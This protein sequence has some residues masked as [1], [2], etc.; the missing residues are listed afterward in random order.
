MRK[1]QKKLR[2]IEH[3]EINISQSLTPE[4]RVKVQNTTSLLIF[5]HSFNISRVMSAPVL[6]STILNRFP[7][8]LILPDMTVLA[9]KRDLDV[10][11]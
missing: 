4:E 9:P 6:N 7:L 2:Q 8:V 1:L 11:P 3:L 5:S 10:A